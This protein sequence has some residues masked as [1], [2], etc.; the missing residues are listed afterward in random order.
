M[1]HLSVG[2]M[3]SKILSPATHDCKQ[4]MRIIAFTG[5]TYFSARLTFIKMDAFQVSPA[6]YGGAGVRR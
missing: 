5:L 6:A 2:N 4:N 3:H 1:R